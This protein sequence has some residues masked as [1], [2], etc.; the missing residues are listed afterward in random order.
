MA[1]F[2]LLSLLYLS[3]LE[4]VLGG[5]VRQYQSSYITISNSNPDNVAEYNFTM[6]FD[7]PLPPNG[8]VSITFPKN[9]YPTGLAPG[10]FAIYAPFPRKILA[11][12]IVDRTVNVPVGAWPKAVPLTVTIQGIKNPSK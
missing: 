8:V 6:S 7:T 5:M 9:Q 1:L 3:N 2:A 4:P 12:T 10:K 11:A